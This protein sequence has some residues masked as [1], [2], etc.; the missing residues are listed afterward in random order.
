MVRAGYALAG[1]VLLVV[2]ICLSLYGF[3]DREVQLWGLFNQQ[4][5]GQENMQA[6]FM[7]VGGIFLAIIGAVALFYGLKDMLVIH[8]LD[9]PE[10]G[11]KAYHKGW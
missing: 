1:A 3:T 8:S 4:W 10:R 6:S 11:R 7:A 2:G 9:K 5:G